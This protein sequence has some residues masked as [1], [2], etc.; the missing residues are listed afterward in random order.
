[1][2]TLAQE[3]NPAVDV[4]HVE[5]ALRIGG[6]SLTRIPDH[7]RDA[8][9]TDPVVVEWVRRIAHL[10]AVRPAAPYVLAGPSLLILGN[11]GTGKTHQAYGAVRALALS[12]AFC[13]WQA[14]TAADLYAALRPRAGV[15]SETEFRRIADAK[16]LLLD[17]LG[18]AKSSEFTEEV[19]YRLINHRYEHELPTIITSNLPAGGIR[20]ALGDRVA[21]RLNEMTTRVVL[22][23]PDRRRQ[24]S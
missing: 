10:A 18:A 1:M 7:Y 3:L 12:G 16:V 5:E 6:H 20:A 14:L 15:D 21:S 24:A 17:D 4:F 9:A 19:N 13:R 23:G 8:E 22:D 11:V 2:T